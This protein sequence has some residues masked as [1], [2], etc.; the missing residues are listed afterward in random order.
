M[1]FEG[2]R[3]VGGRAYSTDGRTIGPTVWHK[4]E[5]MLRKHEETLRANRHCA[6]ILRQG[7]TPLDE[8]GRLLNTVESAPEG[9]NVVADGSR[10]QLRENISTYLM[11]ISQSVV[12]PRFL[13]GVAA[14]RALSKMVSSND[15]NKMDVEGERTWR[16]KKGPSSRQPLSRNTP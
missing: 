14:G 11:L 9:K 6:K 5:K 12:C 7:N 4:S 16:P 1:H 13:P 10:R 8:M 2:L 15:L 3:Q